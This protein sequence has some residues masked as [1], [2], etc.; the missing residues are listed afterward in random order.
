MDKEPEAYFPYSAIIRVAITTNGFDG[1]C[2]Y[3]FGPYGTERRQNVRLTS[4]KAYTETAV[5]F[6]PW[7]LLLPNT[8]NRWTAGALRATGAPSRRFMPC[9][10]KTC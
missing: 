7:P 6:A 2:D 4:A 9:A 8:C 5:S 3:L 1:L 10:L